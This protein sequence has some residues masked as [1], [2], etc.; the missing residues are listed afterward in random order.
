MDGGTAIKSQLI[1]ETLRQRKFL[2]C[3]DLHDLFEQQKYETDI[4]IVCGIC[5]R[6]FLLIHYFRND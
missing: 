5:Y 1:L 3:T 6:N 2:Q 4:H